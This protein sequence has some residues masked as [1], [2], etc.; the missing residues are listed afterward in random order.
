MNNPN[1][2]ADNEERSVESREHMKTCPDC[3][4]TFGRLD[5]M[6]GSLKT[7]KDA[8][9]PPAWQLYD[10]VEAGED[11]EDRL[12]FHLARCHSCREEVQAYKM[13]HEEPAM[14]EGIRAVFDHHLVKQPRAEAPRTSPITSIIDFISSLFRQPTLALGTVAAVA[15]LAVLIYPRPDAGPTLGLSSVN[16]GLENGLGKPKSTA[17]RPLAAMLLYFEGFDKPV[18]QG[19]IDSLYEALRP[20]E[21]LL[22]IYRF[23]AP[24]RLREFVGK[25][26][27]QSERKNLLDKLHKGLHVSEA[28]A[29]TVAPDGGRYRVDLRLFDLTT[30][31]ERSAAWRTNLSKAELPAKLR[32]AV[33]GLLTR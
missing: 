27:G 3:S 7:R 17:K 30:G 14:P 21:D 16:W 33:S 18:P 23:V 8:F 6:I 11:P 32:D 12:S 26:A 1:K 15:L 31:R 5:E 13:G 25:D 24:A 9:C 22:E 2:P 28:L 4:E 29:V 19:E 10:F 20:G